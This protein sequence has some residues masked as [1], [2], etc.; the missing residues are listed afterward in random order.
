MAS[1]MILMND[2]RVLKQHHDTS[3]PPPSQSIIFTYYSEQIG[4]VLVSLNAGKRNNLR[5]YLKVVPFYK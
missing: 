2:Y 4:I 5:T 1:A 3:L